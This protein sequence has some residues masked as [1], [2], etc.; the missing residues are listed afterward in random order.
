PERREI[1]DIND[2]DETLPAPWEWDVKRL[3]TS[4]VLA[5]RNNGFGKADVRGAALA[6]IR[7]YR[8]RMAEFS[9]MRTLDLWYA[10]LDADE[11]IP[12]ISDAEAR[13]RLEK[14]LAKAR[15]QSVAEHDFPKLAEVVGKLPIIK[16]NPP[17]IYHLQEKQHA[18]F[19]GH[20][21]AALHRYRET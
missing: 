1:F 8:K 14:R 21:K 9:E 17:L 6:C 5:S 12:D 4:F 11:L 19:F 18:E 3:A 2:L 16:D 13:R 20:V 15:E 10:R 7:S